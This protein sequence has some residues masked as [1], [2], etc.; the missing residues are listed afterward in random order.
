MRKTPAAD[1]ADKLHVEGEP[2]RLLEAT[3]DEFFYESQEVMADAAAHMPQAAGTTL[4]KD[5]VKWCA[6]YMTSRDLAKR[7]T[8]ATR[9]KHA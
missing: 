6:P 9:S 4:G 3:Q 5:S 7:C 8:A 1:L 2:R